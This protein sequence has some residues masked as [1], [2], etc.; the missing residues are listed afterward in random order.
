MGES[1]VSEALN[2]LTTWVE[3]FDTHL[4]HGAYRE[5]LWRRAGLSGDCSETMAALDIRASIAAQHLGLWHRARSFAEQWAAA[6]K[7][8]HADGPK[9]SIVIPTFNRLSTLERAVQSVAN[10]TYQNIELIVVNDAGESVTSTLDRYR[11]ALEIK[12]IHNPENLYLAG[13]RN[14]GIRHSTG[15]YLNFLDDDDQLYPHHIGH[16]VY[17]AETSGLGASQALSLRQVERRDQ[18]HHSGLVPQT[19]QKFDFPD[20]YL[21]NVT[22][23]QTVLVQRKLIDQVGHFDESFLACEDWDL[24]IRVRAVTPVAQSHTY[25]SWI[26]TRNLPTRMS[27]AKTASF[28]GARAKIF[29]KPVPDGAPVP[30]VEVRSEQIKA[31]ETVS[32]ATYQEVTTQ[33]S[34]CFG[35]LGNASG[36]ADVFQSESRKYSSTGQS[37]GYSH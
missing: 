34:L 35:R 31:L 15:I 30:S 12:E 24:W 1:M 37:P 26:E 6:T 36:R 14:V 2:E 5:I 3:E 7:L 9:V 13:S 25:T 29:S 32:R 21:A 16:L 19:F 22:P 18:T 10:Q 17:L 33:H 23:V 27:I 8:H 28:L 11:D 20:L 4:G